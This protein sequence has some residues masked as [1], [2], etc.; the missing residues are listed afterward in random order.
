MKPAAVRVVLVDDSAELR[1][2]VRSCLER[3]GIEVVAEAADSD[4]AID[5]VRRVKPDVVVLDVGIPGEGAD[6]VIER[7]AAQRPAP[8]VVVFSGWPRA[9]LERL[10]VTVVTKS[11]DPSVLVAEIRRQAEQTC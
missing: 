7:I 9:G 8:R 11:A 2:V 4:G 6:V 1:D 3:E 5:V 10:G